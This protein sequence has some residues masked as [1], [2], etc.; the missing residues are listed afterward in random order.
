MPRDYLVKSVRTGGVRSAIAQI[1]HLGKGKPSEVST[2]I[3]LMCNVY[4]V[5]GNFASLNN[6]FST[7]IET[8]LSPVRDQ[9]ILRR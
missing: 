1:A 9:M 6:V 2:T 3:L 8:T 4:S 5:I 7:Q